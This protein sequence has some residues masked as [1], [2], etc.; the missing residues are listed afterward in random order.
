MED[1]WGWAGDNEGK[2]GL[3]KCQYIKLKSHKKACQRRPEVVQGIEELKQRK[4]MYKRGK[5]FEN[6]SAR[7]LIDKCGRICDKQA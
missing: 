5:L 1:R 3:I 2:G 6:E 4:K 7:L